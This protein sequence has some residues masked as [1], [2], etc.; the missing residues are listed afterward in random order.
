M[1]A[2]AT[3]GFGQLGKGRTPWSVSEVTSEMVG[4]PSVSE[5]VSCYMVSLRRQKVNTTTHLYVS[6]F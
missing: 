1:R 4:N 2:A 3:F 6:V 5:M